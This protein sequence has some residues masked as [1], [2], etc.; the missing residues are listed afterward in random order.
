MTNPNLTYIGLLVD[1][2][3]SMNTIKH[4]MEGGI[5]TFLKEQAT[6]PGEARIT[7]AQ[8]NTVFDKVYTN[9]PIKS[10]SSYTLIPRGAT[11]LNDAVGRLITEMGEQFA[12]SPEESRP[13][14]VVV[15]IVTDGYENS[16]HEW[17]TQQIKDLIT[18]QRT[19]WKWEFLFLGKDIDS[20]SVADSFGISRGNAIDFR[21]AGVTMCTTSGLV[22]A[23]RLA[24]ADAVMDSYSSADREAAME[25]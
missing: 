13:G 11:A 25:S 8:F 18:R 3:G 9:T 7:L 20:F 5:N 1:R 12:A 6:Q 24:G 19:E 2:S 21:N 4:D 17:T 23:Y 16:S 15:V 10:V 22:N 14:K